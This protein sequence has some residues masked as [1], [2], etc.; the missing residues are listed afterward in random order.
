MNA[1]ESEAHALSLAGNTE[2]AVERLRRLHDLDPE[3]PRIYQ[4]AVDLHLAGS[5]WDEARAL[6]DALGSSGP[7]R[8]YGDGLISLYARDYEKAAEAFTEALAGYTALAHPTGVAQSHIGLG[9]VLRFQE[10]L[11]EAEAEL[12]KAHAVYEEKGDRLGVAAGL[13]HLGKVEL[14]RQRIDAALALQHQA[15]ALRERHGDARLQAL[16]W[17]EI[18]RT[19]RQGGKPGEACDALEHVLALRREQ[20]DRLGQ[21]STLGE[22]A[23]SYWDLGD[24][25]RALVPARE[26]I[27]VAKELGGGERR[28]RAELELGKLLLNLGRYEEAVEVLRGPA[29]AGSEAPQERPLQAQIALGNALSSAGRLYEAEELLGDALE[30]ARRQGDRTRQAEAL[31]GL[32]E[33][34]AARRELDAALWLEEQALSLLDD[35]KEPRLQAIALVNLGAVSFRIGDLARAEAQLE[36]AVEVAHGSGER[37]VEALARANLGLALA[38]R[39]AIDAAL[40]KENEAGALWEAAADA[41]ASWA[42]VRTAELLG[43]AGK[44]EMALEAIRL[45]RAELEESKNVK[46]LADALT[47]EADLLREEGRFEDALDGYDRA[48]DL[49]HA[50][51]LVQQEWEARAG[52]ATTLEAQGRTE[53]ASEEYGRALDLVDELR[54]RIDTSELRARF[55]S[56]RVDVY[57]RA[58]ALRARKGDTEGAFSI[59]ERSRARGLLDLLAEARPQPDARERALLD[60]LHSA[61]SRLARAPDARSQEEARA[62]L[63]RAEER[64]QV[65]RIELDRDASSVDPAPVA[66]T[67]VRQ[68]VLD[69]QET[70]L[71]YYVGEG[72]AFVWIASRAGARLYDLPPPAELRRLATALGAAAGH[73]PTSLGGRPAGEAEAEALAAALLPVELP[74]GTRVVI[75]PDGPLHGVPFEALRRNGRPLVEDHEVLVVPS[76]SVLAL[77]REGTHAPAAGGLLG[78]AGPDLASAQGALDRIGGLFPEKE[79]VLLTGRAASRAELVR[80]ELDG[81]RYL[82]FATHGSSDPQAPRRFGLWVGGSAAEPDLLYTDDIFALRLAAEL[83]VLAA[84]GSGRGELVPG[85]GP[86]GA[87]RA[88]LQAGARSV[89]VSLW[90]VSDRSTAEFME[91]F[92]GELR[93]G[94]PVPD[95]LRRTKLAFIHSDRPAQ[96]QIFRWAPF[97]LIGDP[98]RIESPNVVARGA[99]P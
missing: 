95:A 98:G 77:M 44:R 56:G 34:R 52:R 88:F 62:A 31:V 29:T 16:S 65:L 66:L 46:W 6:M 70:L 96:R 15:L 63:D 79:R 1:L 75:A 26:S 67:D 43:R 17:Q 13:Y 61:A 18:G 47:I 14:A 76:A 68:R 90:D 19:L 23:R 64:L 42:R 38:E 92:Y 54:L 41:R 48:L 89:I 9:T 11:D 22:L 81:F 21:Y 60:E 36:R 35:G 72:Q 99:T 28:A 53:E 78:V 83:V 12:R 24:R 84:C 97:V 10:R 73:P 5:R 20:G 86:L 74:A 39:G 87:A 25:E 55:L 71:S 30:R 33:V 85:E 94:R 27:E 80:R 8:C 93:R 3:H 57:E 7:G 82:Y 4:V 59:A 58:L 49:C 50:R 2:A 40:S 32:G 51:D 45:S 91:L 69:P 37:W